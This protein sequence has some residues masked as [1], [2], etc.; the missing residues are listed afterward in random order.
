MAQAYTLDPSQQTVYVAVQQPQTVYYVEATPPPQQ[1]IYQVQSPPIATPQ[2]QQHKRIVV[3]PGTYLPGTPLVVGS[4][5]VV[6]ERYLSEGGFAH[7]YVVRLEHS[8]HG[9]DLAVLKRVAVP[10]KESLNVLR[11]EV[12]TMKRLRGHPNAVT[13]IDSHASHLKAGGYEVFVLMEFCSGG[14]LIDFMNT[15]LQNRFTES[16]ILKIFSDIVE[17]VSGMHYLEP[18]LI[19]RDLKVENVLISESGNFKICDFGSSCEAIPA[20]KTGQECRAIEDDI[21]R[22]TTM[23]YRSP[24]MVDVYRGL[25]IDEKSDIWALGVLLYKLCYYTTPFEEQGQLAILNATFTFPPHPQYTDRLKR[26]ISV[27]LREN[28]RDRPNIYQVLKEVCR[29]RGVEVPIRDIYSERHAS[30]NRPRP[31]PSSTTPKKQHQSTPSIVQYESRTSKSSSR[32]NIPEIKPMRRGRVPPPQAATPAAAAAPSPSMRISPLPARKLS[33]HEELESPSEL[34]D[35]PSYLPPPSPPAAEIDQSEVDEAEAALASRFPSLKDSRPPTIRKLS[36]KAFDK[37]ESAADVPPPKPARPSLDS[38]RTS[39]SSSNVIKSPQPKRPVLVATGTSETAQNKREFSDGSSRMAPVMQRSNSRQDDYS[40]SGDFAPPMRAPS[41]GAMT[42]SDSRRP[43]LDAS[44][45]QSSSGSYKF[46]HRPPSSASGRKSRPVSMFLDSSVDF[47]RNLGR[48]ESPANSVTGGDAT[49]ALSAV[50]TGQSQKSEHIESNL[51]FLKSLDTGGSNMGGSERR[52]YTGGSTKAS[53]PGEMRSVS[54]GSTTAKHSKRA[55][56]PVINL[57]SKLTGKFGEAFKKFE[58]SPVTTGTSVASVAEQPPPSPRTPRLMSFERRRTPS[59]EKKKKE[60]EGVATNTTGGGGFRM[61]MRRASSA[62]IFRRSSSN[63]RNAQPQKTGEQQ[64]QQQSSTSSSMSAPA[65]EASTSS[66]TSWNGAREALTISDAM[67]KRAAARNQRDSDAEL[68]PPPA[69]IAKPKPPAPKP[70]A[71]V[72]STPEKSRGSAPAVPLKS[73]GAASMEF[74]IKTSAAVTGTGSRRPRAESIQNRVQSLLEQSQSAPVSKSASGY[75]K[76]TDHGDDEKAPETAGIKRADTIGEVESALVPETYVVIEP[77]GD[78]EAE[79]LGSSSKFANIKGS[80]EAEFDEANFLAQARQ[81]AHSRAKQHLHEAK[82]RFEQ[83]HHHIRTHSKNPSLTLVDV[84]AASPFESSSRSRQS[85]NSS[86]DGSAW[87][88][89]A[90]P[91]KPAKLQVTGATTTTTSSVTSSPARSSVAGD[92]SPRKVHQR[93]FV[94]DNADVK[95]WEVSFER[96]FPSLP[97]VDVDDDEEIEVEGLLEDDLS[98]MDIR[99][100]ARRFE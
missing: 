10:D 25:P 82:N 52:Q 22:H 31:A 3:P 12:D 30:S 62:K 88:R 20:G 73:S 81:K 45:N 71:S 13:Y 43:S 34:L 37:F 94:H 2:P 75:G 90:P 39:S 48:S 7:V 18:P 91:P 50:Y 80:D 14:G 17:G 87:D 56:M 54:A 98:R 6:I 97:G 100:R 66:S 4:H 15:R 77:M 70:A 29:M 84:R 99:E 23:Q 59:P 9:T 46:P 79:L 64:Q 86:A 38:N 24:E 49:G 83:R 60:D 11:I 44:R 92:L 8:I 26:L 58:Q 35:Y 57:S 32:Q 33:H 42:P 74:P 21:Q 36:K 40:S 67:E 47:L 95:D 65:M 61:H 41:R 51:E 85:T 89:P 53:V 55:S 78:V 93:K 19:H 72:A 68:M 28:P 16:E 96:K 5:N 27:M 63:G 1:V 69:A 76:Y